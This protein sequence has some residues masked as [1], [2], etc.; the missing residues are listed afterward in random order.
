MDE[1][2]VRPLR[3]VPGTPRHCDVM[4]RRVADG[5]ICPVCHHGLIDPPPNRRPEPSDTKETT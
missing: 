5:W 4:M 1:R 3:E 2:L